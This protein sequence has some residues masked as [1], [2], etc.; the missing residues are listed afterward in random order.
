MIL[1]IFKSNLDAFEHGI[2]PAVVK[3]IP[4]D[5]NVAELY[6]GKYYVAYIVFNYLH[7]FITLIRIIFIFYYRFYFQ[8]FLLLPWGYYS[9]TLFLS[10]LL[11]SLFYFIFAP[12]PY[13]LPFFPSFFI[14]ILSSLLTSILL[15]SYFPIF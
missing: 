5:S 6:S 13:H 14:S 9:P 3:H 10:I 4:I 11:R 15:F 7:L 8:I 1:I 2:I 12:Y